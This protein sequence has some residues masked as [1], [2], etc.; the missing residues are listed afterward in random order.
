MNEQLTADLLR[1]RNRVEASSRSATLYERRDDEL[2]QEL[3]PE[4]FTTLMLDVT[5]AADREWP[6]LANLLATR[7][8]LEEVILYVDQ[9]SEF[10][11]G[12]REPPVWQGA[13]PLLALYRRFLQAMQQNPVIHKVMLD[14]LTFLSG[15]VIGNYLSHTASPLT[16]L[17]LSLSFLQPGTDPVPDAR[18]VV[19]ALQRHST[20]LHTL[21]FDSY[22]E[23]YK[24][25]V[26]RVLERDNFPAIR[27]LV[28]SGVNSDNIYRAY[29]IVV[30]T[31]TTIEALEFH[32]TSM[33]DG[34]FPAFSQAIVNSNSVTHLKFYQ[35]QFQDEESTRSFCN[36]ID[37]KQSISSLSL[38]RNGFTTEPSHQ[39]AVIRCLQ[40][41]SALRA[42]E[43]EAGLDINRGDNRARPIADPMPLLQAVGKSDL[44]TFR[45]GSV[46]SAPQLAKVV[47]PTSRLHQLELRVVTPPAG[48]ME[49]K[50]QLVRAIKGNFSLRIVKDTGRLFN[51]DDWKQL[52]QI[53]ERNVG[54]EK[55]IANVASLPEYVWPEV[56]Y[57]ATEV[58]PTVL[59]EAIRSI[60]STF[61]VER[62]DENTQDQ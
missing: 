37:S 20:S 16:S 48:E 62:A 8:N 57:R 25:A 17:H 22:N 2:V 10:K 56:V 60:G 30:E 23:V 6:L 5:A 40:P 14:S 34:W 38:T 26:L 32:S 12:T 41:G 50:H 47:T 13:I 27:K 19:L 18:L 58:E 44:L 28:I 53:V 21:H 15:E 45:F 24:L 31:C 49:G 1:E 29:R 59:F 36:M 52:K 3:L 39:E 43:F 9:V 42:L 35:C 51:R 46:Q 55:W 61:R 7:E 54:L 4:T 11:L 33:F